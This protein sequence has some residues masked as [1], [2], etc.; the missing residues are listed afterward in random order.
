M[1]TWDETELA[2]ETC[3]NCGAVYSVTYKSLPLKDKDDFRCSCGQPMRSW[4][5]TGMYMY[6]LIS[7]GE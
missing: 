4:K 2:D 5:E 3:P 6:A 7:E 1:A